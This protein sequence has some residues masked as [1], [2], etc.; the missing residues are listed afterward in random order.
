MKITITSSKTGKQ[1]NVSR[2]LSYDIDTSIDIPADHFNVEIANP[3]GENSGLF[4]ANDSVIIEYGG[5][6]IL[7][8]IIDDMRSTVDNT[9]ARITLDGRD[10]SLLLLDNDAIPQ[11]YYNLTLESFIKKI[12]TPYGFTKFDIAKTETV[13]KI[14][15]E[16]GQTEWEAIYQQAYKKMGL[17]PWVTADGTFVCKKLN[18]S[19][20]PTHLFS[21]ELPGAINYTSST[22]RLTLAGVKSEVLAK[23]YKE[24]GYPVARKYNPLIQEGFRR[25]R[26][27]ED[28]EAENLKELIRNSDEFLEDSRRGSYEVTLTCKSNFAIKPNQTA[29]VFDRIHKVDNVFWIVGVR[30]TLA[31]E[32]KTTTVRMWRIGEAF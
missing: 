25:R 16:P 11:A 5:T 21:N 19:R 30:H 12:A 7:N 13:A 10:K 14:K 32:G 20:Q 28:G 27:I 6:V 31:D 2:F 9:G 29:R 17:M 24:K 26:V 18:Y 8:G 15:I 1:Y 4:D 22:V 3:Y 23:T